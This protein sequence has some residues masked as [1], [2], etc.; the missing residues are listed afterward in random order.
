MPT[1]S[2][3]PDL[4]ILQSRQDKN[5]HGERYYLLA[6]RVTLIFTT[7]GLKAMVITLK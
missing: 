2:P 3:F 4:K 6:T 5:N 1:L 7:I